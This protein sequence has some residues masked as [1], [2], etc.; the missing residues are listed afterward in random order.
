MCSNPDTYIRKWN[1]CYLT[2]SRRSNEQMLTLCLRRYSCEVNGNPKGSGNPYKGN[3]P[4]LRGPGLPPGPGQAY[5]LQTS[6]EVSL[7]P[8]S[9]YSV[10][11]FTTAS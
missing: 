8:L 1:R 10:A 3:S 6:G 7:T 11:I 4:P 5:T 9:V 2:E